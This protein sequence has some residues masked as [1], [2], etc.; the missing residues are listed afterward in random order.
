MK[1]TNSRSLAVASGLAGHKKKR[2][3]HRGVL[4]RAP[5]CP[6]TTEGE[7]IA[8]A[9]WAAGGTAESKGRE[10]RSGGWSGSKRRINFGRTAARGWRE[11]GELGEA[12]IGCRFCDP[13]RS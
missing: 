11:R 8:K 13:A 7:R 1:S 9:R 3:V 4:E 6:S 5:W 10:I 2:F 12:M